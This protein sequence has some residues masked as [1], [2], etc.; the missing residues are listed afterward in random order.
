M[1]QGNWQ[2]QPQTES[3]AETVILKQEVDWQSRIPLKYID[4]N[5]KAK[6]AF[7]AKTGQKWSSLTEDE[8]NRVKREASDYDKYILLEGFEDVARQR[9]YT[10]RAIDIIKTDL[11]HSVASCEIHW[12]PENGKPL[13]VKEISA[14]NVNNVEVG[15]GIDFRT[16][17]D[18]IARNRAFICCVKASLGIKIFGKDEIKETEDDVP[19]ENVLKGFKGHLRDKMKTMLKERKISFGRV[20]ERMER[21]GVEW[22]ENWTEDTLPSS[23]CSKVIT[24]LKQKNE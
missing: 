7:E 22:N 14:A 10:Y 13:I 21:D 9:G 20:R 15:N 18:R 12:L 17:L 2:E 1:T 24:L 23:I 19:N 6:A 5:K 4:L 3:I 8:K 16:F 11:E